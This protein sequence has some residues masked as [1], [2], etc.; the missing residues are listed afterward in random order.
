MNI[1]S[2]IKQLVS[3]YPQ[4]KCE[5]VEGNYFYPFEV[6][7]TIEYYTDSKYLFGQKDELGRDK[8]FLNRVNYRLITAVKA[9]PFSTKDIQLVPDGDENTL[10]VAL[11]DHELHDW[12]KEANYDATIDEMRYVRPKHGELIVKKIEKNGE[13]KIEVVDLRNVVVDPSSLYRTFIEVQYM[14][15]SELAKQKGWNTAELLSNP[16]A[17]T[18]KMKIMDGETDSTVDQYEVYEVYGEFPLSMIE[19]GGDENDYR[20]YRLYIC[21]DTILHQAEISEFPYK[22]LSWEAVNGRSIGRGVVEAGFEAQVWSNDAVLKQRDMMEHASKITFVTD[23]DDVEDNVLTDYDSGSIIKIGDGKSF[24]MLN[25]VPTSLPQINNLLQMWDTQYQEVSSSF[26]AVTGASMPSRTPFRT[27]AMLNQAGA[28]DFAEK[29]KAF[30]IFQ[31]EIIYDW[32]L[33]YLIKKLKSGHRLLVDFSKEEMDLFEED[34]ANFEVNKFVKSEILKGRRITMEELAQL[35]ELAKAK[36]LTRRIMDIPEGYY[37]DIRTKVDIITS[38]ENIDKQ[39]MFESLNNMLMT[40]AQN[41][42]IMTDPMLSKL[43]GKIIDLAGVGISLPELTANL[44]QNVDTNQANVS[45]QGIG[46][47]TQGIQPNSSGQ[48]NTQGG[49]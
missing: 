44:N 2:H 47:G 13:L 10:R 35:R 41:P 3:N 31:K 12:F 29:N 17:R 21:N 40:V 46:G 18:K 37:A 20:L 48:A 16:N 34:F 39:A 49:F 6:I 7:K 15:P 14:T 38:G 27:M 33:P 28:S 19:D 9:T 32:V 30:G 36:K 4:A 45:G 11:L 43:F 8:P 5:R 22:N 24:K 26:D 42:Q 23:D 25:T 1:Q